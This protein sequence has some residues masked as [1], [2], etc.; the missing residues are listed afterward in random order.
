MVDSDLNTTRTL[1]NSDL[2]TTQT[3]VNSNLIFMRSELTSD[4]VRIDRKKKKVR[5][6]RAELTKVRIHH[7]PFKPMCHNTS[8]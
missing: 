2:N 1:V 4:K 3:L 5:I 8:S 6:A 7:V